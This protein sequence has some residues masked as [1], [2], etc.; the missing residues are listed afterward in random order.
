MPPKHTGLV[1]P[2]Y[3]IEMAH[4]DYVHVHKIDKDE[5]A[6]GILG[7]VHKWWSG[8]FQKV[9]SNVSLFAEKEI[10]SDPTPGS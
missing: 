10:P 7:V 1:Y 3:A 4:P 5:P 8:H 9:L 2:K 6:C